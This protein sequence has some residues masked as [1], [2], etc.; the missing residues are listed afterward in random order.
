MDEIDIAE[1]QRLLRSPESSKAWEEFLRHYSP[2]ILQVVKSFE[3]DPDHVADCFLFV[4]EKLCERRFRRLLCFRPQGPAG[5]PTWL[6]AVTR[7]LCLDWH[8]REFGRHRVFEA[9]SRL[10]AFDQDVFRVVIE[11]GH[12]AET[13]FLILQPRYPHIKPETFSQSAEQ[14][15]SLLTARQ[16]WLLTVQRPVVGSIDVPADDAGDVGLDPPDPAP[17]PEEVFSLAELHEVLRRAVTALSPRER[18]LIRLRFQHELTLQQVSLALNLGS[19]QE[20]DRQIREVL[21]RLKASLVRKSR[22]V[23]ENEEGRP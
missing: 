8:R 4:C 13:A 14:I 12:P 16:R 15:Q 11:Q 22:P 3:H 7:N 20:A 9:I 1:L 10:S 5:F 17:G 18:M 19:P 6:R 21:V 2:V 23:A